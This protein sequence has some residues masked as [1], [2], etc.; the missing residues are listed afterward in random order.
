MLGNNTVATF[1]N[2]NPTKISNLYAWYRGDSAVY[3]GSNKVS[4]WRD[5]SGN[6]NH[7]TQSNASFQPSYSASISSRKNQPGVAASGGEYLL[8][9]AA[10]FNI[11]TL[12]TV[13]FVVGSTGSMAYV[14]TV[15]NGGVEYFYA[16][17]PAPATFYNRTVASGQH[18]Y[19]T[20]AG[21]NFFQA[22]THHT[23]LYDNVTPQLFRN[24]ANVAGVITGAPIGDEYA[25]G[26]F[27]LFSGYGGGTSSTMQLLEVIFYNKALNAT[28]L[29]AMQRYFTERYG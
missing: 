11:R 21:A 20:N 28:E 4:Q 3:N 24:N 29:A 8:T 16:Y 19:I 23:F 7:L 10:N 1:T 12:K 13:F 26:S 5:L 6:G 22:N 2:Y 25:S 14:S 27:Y 18:H 9:N 17:H 15:Y